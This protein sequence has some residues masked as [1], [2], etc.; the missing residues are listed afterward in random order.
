MGYTL[1]FQLLFALAS[2]EP[3]ELLRRLARCAV[4]YGR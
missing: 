4:G 3:M 1:L 2:Q